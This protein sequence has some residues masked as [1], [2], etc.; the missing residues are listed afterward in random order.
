MSDFELEFQM[1][2]MNSHLNPELSTILLMPDEKHIHL[3][4]N[5]VKEIARLHGDIAD[6]VPLAVHKHLKAK[7][8]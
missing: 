7:F 4:S 3:N 8:N 6:Y 2:M 5:L 1:A